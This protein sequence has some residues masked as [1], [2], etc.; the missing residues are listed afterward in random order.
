VSTEFPKGAFGDK[1][2]LA[3]KAA[4]F[5]CHRYSAAKLGEIGEFF[6]MKDSAVSQSS[7]RLMMALSKDQEFQKTVSDLVQ[8]LG[9]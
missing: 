9:L 5:L 2:R 6:G 8:R 7:R 3:G 1:E 4:I